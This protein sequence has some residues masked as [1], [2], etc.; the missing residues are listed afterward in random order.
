MVPTQSGSVC[1]SVGSNTTTVG[2][3]NGWAAPDFFFSLVVTPATW[4]ISAMAKEFG[5]AICGGR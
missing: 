2:M 1:A 4:V 3:S 5:Q